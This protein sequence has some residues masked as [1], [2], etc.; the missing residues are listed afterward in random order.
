QLRRALLSAFLG[1]AE[2]S[3]R[4]GADRLARFRCARGEACEAAAALEAVQIFRLASDRE[5]QVVMALLD[6]LC[7]MLTRLAGLTHNRASR[8]AQPH[9]SVPPRLLAPPVPVLASAPPSVGV[10]PVPAAPDP[11][12]PPVPP[13]PVVPPLPRMEK[14]PPPPL[15]DPVD[16]PMP[17]GV[18]GGGGGHIPFSHVVPP[19]Q[20]AP[21]Q[22][23][24]HEPP[25]QTVPAGQV[26]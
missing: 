24:L 7:A 13:A 10:T 3:S 9:A 20:T 19:G 16:P 6:R 11:P 26:L 23:S 21:V 22:A 8:T 14:P 12:R 25:W 4:S 1:I 18:I 15:P 5:I 2:A 17:V